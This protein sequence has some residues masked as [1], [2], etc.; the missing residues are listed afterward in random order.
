MVFEAPTQ[1]FLTE[2]DPQLKF[3]RGYAE[4]RPFAAYC[5][6][7]IIRIGTDK[8][9]LLSSMIIL[10][11]QP[12]DQ[13]EVKRLVLSGLGEHWGRI[14]PSKNPNLDD[15][16]TNYASATFLVACWQNLIVATGALV[17]RPDRKAE[18]VRMSVAVDMR[19]K[20]I[21]RLILDQL[22]LRARAAGFRQVI[23]E[24]TATWQE[25]IE[26]YLRYGFYITHYQDGDV[27]FALDLDC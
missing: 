23:L 10:P 12:E 2:L 1:A 25:V 14:N 13:D 26:S 19:R 3:V 6:E 7:S 17:P 15:I 16:A 27:F 11:F 9:K 4:I 5:Q 21:G 24:T 18:V 22:V 20:G 8:G